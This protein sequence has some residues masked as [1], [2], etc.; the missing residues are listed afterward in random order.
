MWVGRDE[1]VYLKKNNDILRERLEFY[2]SEIC[3]WHHKCDDLGESLK[4]AKSEIDSY[5]NLCEEYKQKYADEV[6]KRLELIEFYD[7]IPLDK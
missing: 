7:K 3:I 6:Q 2:E 5:K 4:K 1:Y